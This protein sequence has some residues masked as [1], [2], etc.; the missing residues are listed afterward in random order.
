MDI[1]EAWDNFR[2]KSFQ[3]ASVQEQLDTLAAAINEIRTDTS[4]TAEI[5]PQI[6]GDNAAIDSANAEAGA[7]MPGAPDMGGMGGEDMN[8][9]DEQMPPEGGDMGADMGEDMGATPE[10]GAEDM[11]APDMGGD[12]AMPP[13]E[14]GGEYEGES[15]DDYM[16]DEDI[17]ALL[18][19]IYGDIKADEEEPTSDVPEMGVQEP[20]IPASGGAGLAEATNNLLAALK[21]AAHEAVDMNDIDRVVELSHMEQQIM[22]TLGN[23]VG[24]E[25]PTMGEAPPMGADVPEEQTP[26]DLPFD[27]EAAP[28]VSEEGTV[29]EDIMPE[30]T[31]AAPEAEEPEDK[32]EDKDDEDVKKSATCDDAG[33]SP[34]SFE[35]DG[36]AGGDMGGDDGMAEATMDDEIGGVV[37]SAD[38]IPP[39]PSFKDMM[40]GK[41]DMVAFMKGDCEGYIDEAQI[42]KDPFVDPVEG[43][44]D[45]KTSFMKADDRIATARSIFDMPMSRSGHKDPA[46]IATAGEAQEA[47]EHTG[48]QDPESISTADKIIDVKKSA[49]DI[50][51]ISASSGSTD[52]DS[53]ASAGTAQEALSHE[54]TQD[55]NS[56]ASA[57]EAVDM[58]SG[59]DSEGSKESIDISIEKSAPMGDDIDSVMDYLKTVPPDQHDKVLRSIFA[60]LGLKSSSK[61]KAPKADVTNA[62]KPPKGERFK[63]LSKEERAKAEADDSDDEEFDSELLYSTPP[64]YMYDDKDSGPT[65][66]SSKDPKWENRKNDMWYNKQM[67][68][69]VNGRPMQEGG[70]EGYLR[71]NWSDSVRNTINADTIAEEKARAANNYNPEID[72]MDPRRPDEFFGGASA[73]ASGGKPH[74][75]YTQEDIDAHYAHQPKSTE[76]LLRK[77]EPDSPTTMGIGKSL[78]GGKHMMTLNEAFAIAKSEGRPNMASAMGDAMNPD[79]NRIQ[80]SARPIVRMGRGV[81][82]MKVI[83]NDLEEW[84][85]Y[86]ARSKF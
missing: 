17:D 55:P 22:Q 84:N 62:P 15:E 37:K 8:A 11:M 30:E 13:M 29:E 57:K 3:K 53:I 59:N 78:E 19:S 48:E 12:E 5:V 18:D 38:Y 47:L 65:R 35:K 77:Y 43:G 2:S 74:N 68:E 56:V 83:E 16:S 52:P 86:K 75:A 51:K 46:S 14:G 21:Q 67:D 44:I 23:E 81:D 20:T 72:D 39:S 70:P 63:S 33:N 60:D 82:P 7:A 26:M 9:M 80:K 64:D 58:D 41:V 45:G 27:P 85:L 71:R 73:A 32:E 50:G 54:G 61:K 40:S 6:M 31:E 28:D 69:V 25:E 1:E 34:E 24:I 36:E 10:P 4:R 42:Y 76:D 79:L 49:E 66:I